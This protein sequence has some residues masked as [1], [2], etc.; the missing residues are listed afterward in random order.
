MFRAKRVV[1]EHPARVIPVEL[2]ESG[3]QWV[4]VNPCDCGERHVHGVG[5]GLGYRLS[6]CARSRH[7]VLLV[8]SRLR[9]TGALVLPGEPLPA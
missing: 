7:P 6:H 2:D 9:V 3:T 1:E 5:G 8:S 4:Y